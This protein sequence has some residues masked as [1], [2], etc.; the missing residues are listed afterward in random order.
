VMRREV[1]EHDVITGAELGKQPVRREKNGFQRPRRMGSEKREEWVE[2]REEKNGFQRP[3]QEVGSHTE[4][5]WKLAS[6]HSASRD[7][8]TLDGRRTDV[9]SVKRMTGT[10]RGRASPQHLSKW[11]TPALNRGAYIPEPT[12]YD[13]GDD[14]FAPGSTPRRTASRATTTA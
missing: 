12:W 6:H 1:V 13:L 3:L 14:G 9:A 7:R 11:T 2:K 10:T 8:R 4:V 5:F